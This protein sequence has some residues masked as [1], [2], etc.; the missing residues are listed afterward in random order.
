MNCE[1]TTAAES[2]EESVAGRERQHQI[3]MLRF[4]RDSNS[5]NNAVGWYQSTIMEQYNVAQTVDNQYKHQLELGQRCVCLVFDPVRSHHG[6]LE[7]RALRLTEQFMDAVRKLYLDAMEQKLTA[8]IAAAETTVGARQQTIEEERR[9]LEDLRELQKVIPTAVM[10]Q[11]IE[12]ITITQEL[13]MTSR[14]RKMQIFEE[15]P[16]KINNS[17]LVDAYMHDLTRAN[18]ID[19]DI[20]FDCLDLA[21]GPYLESELGGLVE[22][23]DDLLNDLKELANYQ[24]RAARARGRPEEQPSRLNG[25]MIGK[26][27]DNYVEQLNS[28]AAQS[29]NK[30][31]LAKSTMRQSD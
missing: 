7:L 19:N 4:M 17:A 21:S 27:M 5:D 10:P 26:Q 15:V 28:Y 29:I 23:S 12:D 3:D 31:Y 8:T 30:I 20:S 22:S 13:L 24:R 25:I 18:F 6:H 2:G 1:C 9:K 11:S 14:F 16:I